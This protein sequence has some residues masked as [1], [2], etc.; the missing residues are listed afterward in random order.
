MKF[1]SAAFLSWLSS[2]WEIGCLVEGV[3]NEATAGQQ[4]C[5]IKHIREKLLVYITSTLSLIVVFATTLKQVL[6]V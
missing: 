1:W 6:P 4:T 5:Y 3:L 2:T